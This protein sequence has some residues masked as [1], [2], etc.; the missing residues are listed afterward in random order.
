MRINFMFFIIPFEFSFVFHRFRS[1]CSFKMLALDFWNVVK[2]MVD[3]EDERNKEF[4]SCKL[5]QQAFQINAITCQYN[6]SKH[7]YGQNKKVTY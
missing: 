7:S 1:F 5:K 3:N 4:H 2:I 6:I